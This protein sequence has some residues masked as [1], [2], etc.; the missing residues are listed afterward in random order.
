[1]VR[2]ATTEPL[3][4]QRQSTSVRM[5]FTRMVQKRG[6]ARVVV[7]GMAAYLSAGDHGGK[8]LLYLPNYCLKQACWTA[9]A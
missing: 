5:V 3:Q 7:Y 9:V 2:S 6:C 4:G 1:V 8:Y